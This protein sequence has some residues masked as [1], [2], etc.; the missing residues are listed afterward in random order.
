MVAIEVASPQHSA[1]QTGAHKP[2]ALASARQP[3]RQPPAAALGRTAPDVTAKAPARR[4]RSDGHTREA[5]ARWR[6]S[7]PEPTRS[8]VELLGVPSSRL[9]VS[10]E[11]SKFSFSVISLTFT[12][13]PSAVAFVTGSSSNYSQRTFGGEGAGF[14]N[15]LC[16]HHAG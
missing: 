4:T 14:I 11:C 2:E 5:P 3:A 7:N 13:P 10:W 9:Q 16:H 12:F 8:D 15:N 6:T 1:L